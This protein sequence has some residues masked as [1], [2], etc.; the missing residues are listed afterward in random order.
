MSHCQTVFGYVCYSGKHLRL[1]VEFN[2]GSYPPKVIPALHELHIILFKGVY[3]HG[4]PYR[5]C[6]H[7]EIQSSLR[8]PAFLGT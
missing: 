4:L 7:D 5:K 8:C 3:K 1:T 2:F 6:L